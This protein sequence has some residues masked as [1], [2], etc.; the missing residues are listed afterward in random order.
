MGTQGD[1]YEAALN[2]IMDRCM[3][4]SACPLKLVHAEVTGQGPL[5]GV[6]YGHAFVLDGNTV[7]DPSNGRMLELPKET[8][9]DIGQIDKND[10][11]IVYD[12]PAAKKRMVEFEHYGPWDLETSTGL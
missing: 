1:C 2:F 10:N 9:Y 4:N 8:Y 6:N 3:F 5:E 7:I 11:T 12:W